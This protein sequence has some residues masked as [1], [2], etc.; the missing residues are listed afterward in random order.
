MTMTPSLLAMYA[1]GRPWLRPTA[2]TGLAAPTLATRRSPSPLTHFTALETATHAIT[3]YVSS[4][5]ELL[6]RSVSLPR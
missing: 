1:A 3:G 4:L 5:L 6:V 2:S